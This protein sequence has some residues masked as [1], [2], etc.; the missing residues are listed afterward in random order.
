MHGSL[1]EAPTLGFSESVDA[2]PLAVAEPGFGWFI[3]PQFNTF[4]PTYNAK[5]E[6]MVYH[7]CTHFIC[8]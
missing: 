7:A 3:F 8:F 2:V 4:L 1:K 5:A 6:E